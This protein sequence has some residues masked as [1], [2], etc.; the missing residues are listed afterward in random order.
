MIFVLF[1]ILAEIPELPTPHNPVINQC[2]KAY[3][4]QAGISLPSSFAEENVPNCGA[5]CFPTSDGADLMNYKIY[6]NQLYT[7]CTVELDQLQEDNQELQEI[8]NTPTPFMEQPVVNRWLGSAEGAAV[9]VLIGLVAYQ[10]YQ[11]QQE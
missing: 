8:I 5:I 3:P 11:T 4:A 6:A 7:V 1:S 10:L 2:A 9:G